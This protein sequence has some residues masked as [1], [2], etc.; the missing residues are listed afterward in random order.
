M[1]VAAGVWGIDLGQCALKAIKLQYD[2]KADKAVAIAFD[3]VEHPKIL[4]QPDA[5][6]EELIRNALEK[7][8][9]RN[10][11][12][13]CDIYTSV[14]TQSG[15]ARFVKLPPVDKKKV[16]DIVQFEAK[17]QI[18]FPLE[19]VAWDYQ[20]IGG[21][22][23]EEGGLALETEVGIFA[24]KRDMVT[25]HM[26]PLEAAGLEVTAVQLAGVALYNYA[27]SDYFY[28]G[29]K[30]AAAPAGEA[31][32]L[33]SSE[34]T[35]D[36]EGDAIVI[37]DIGA[38]KTD[39]VITDGDT[40]WLRNL[41][42]GGNHFTRALSKGIQLTFAKAEHLKRNAT[43]A[44]DPKKLYQ[45]M[46]PVFQDFASELQRS[47]GYYQQTHR[48]VNIKRLLG[49]GNGFK[50]PGL[51][52][53]LQ[54]SLQ[55]DVVRA[56]RFYGLTGDEV[57]ASSVF[58]D[59]APSFCVAYG[60]ALQGL[61]QTPIQTNL[62]P[63]EIQV[64]RLIRAKKPWSLAA[65]AAL[66]LGCLVLFV[67]NWRVYSA[68]HAKTFE[69]PEAAAKTAVA[70]FNRWD[71]EF[72]QSLQTFE[73]EKK[74][75]A[76][77]V[78]VD[79]LDKRLG[80]IAVLKIINDTIPPRS[81][82]PDESAL[83]KL[84]EVNIEFISA[85]H[86]KNLGEWFNKFEPSVK[87]TL[88]ETDKKGPPAGAGWVF[89]VLGYTFHE[90]GQ[91]FVLDN[92]LRRFQAEKLR[93]LGLTHALLSRFAEDE[94]WTPAS[95]SPILEWAGIATTTAGGRVAGATSPAAGGA[96]S[97]VAAAP[98][99]TS[100]GGG[101]WGFNLGQA[102]EALKNQPQGADAEQRRS[103]K[104]RITRDAVMD[105]A[106]RLEMQVSTVRP[107]M[108]EYS[109][110]SAMRAAESWGEESA[111]KRTDFELQFVWVPKI[112]PAQS[113]IEP[114]APKIAGG[115]APVTAAPSAVAPA[116]AVPAGAAPG[117][118][119]PGATVSGAAA[120]AAAAPSARTPAPQ[121]AT[122]G[123]AAI[124]PMPATKSAAT[125]STKPANPPSAPAKETKPAGP[126][127][128]AA[129]AGS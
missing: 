37:L 80:W 88:A 86:V 11:V 38:D 59:N 72:K 90:N 81:A 91:L 65:A 52:K 23:E 26:R 119:V 108:R 115:A 36:E 127:T 124:Q 120:L 61:H 15:L 53:F 82:N 95:R 107:E 4:S 129:A 104:I 17:Q 22:G 14:P 79:L 70:E 103:R 24:I 66:L 60:L 41:P 58:T 55:F 106:S 3:Y 68:V 73:T 63:K 122:P 30:K 40:I 46:R 113:V 117:A 102:A 78:G 71:S 76:Q 89:R 31:A 97:P 94:K 62:L 1:A 92:V 13:G 44:P 51:Q 49:V 28:H 43:K 114:A 34:A 25:R 54:Q 93:E 85:E 19:D 20:K 69:A 32:A 84:E 27:A 67:G 39:V 112:S 21:S 56:D 35:E 7:F 50:L 74:S 123:A 125:P 6:P 5:D 126:A 77:L 42:I 121:A 48:D 105:G 45:A 12:E 109:R 57:L 100:G 64:A 9:S 87:D 75:G 33:A 128:K 10:D 47:I 29:R 101:G 111:F 8:L 110:S 83:E 2:A 118:V 18:P 99:A 116:A 16:P 98:A 96:A